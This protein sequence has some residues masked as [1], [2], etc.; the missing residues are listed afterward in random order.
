MDKLNQI[1]KLI[2]GGG[3][4]SSQLQEK[5]QSLNTEIFATYGMTETVTHIAVK[6]LN[7]FGST[8]F[9]SDSHFEI[10]PHVNISQDKRGCLIIWI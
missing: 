8:D 1:K 9:V 4:V 6:K 2:V 3:A 7:N 5:L 10:L